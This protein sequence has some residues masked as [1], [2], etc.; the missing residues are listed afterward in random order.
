M[1]IAYNPDGASMT[2]DDLFAWCLSVLD[3]V[4]SPGIFTAPDPAVVIQITQPDYPYIFEASTIA[5]D[6]VTLG[7][8][9]YSKLRYTAR[10]GNW[11][12]S[13]IWQA[14]ISDWRLWYAATQ[15]FRLPFVVDLPDGSGGAIVRAPCAFPLALTAFERWGTN[16]ADSNTLLVQEVL[17]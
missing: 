15:G 6:R 14:E 9:G 5:D 13:N 12:F 7:G 10:M 16:G 3:L 2:R 4:V 1:N 17:A 8:I 11:T